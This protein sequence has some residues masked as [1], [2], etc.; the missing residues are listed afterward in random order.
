MDHL[1][2]GTL[3]DRLATQIGEAIL[4]GDYSSGERLDEQRLAEAYAVSR[5]PV[6]EALRQL[7]SSGLIEIRPHRGAIVATITP[8]RL[9]ELFVAMG[10]IEATCA[11]LAAISMSP[12]ERRQLDAL[13]AE[14]G[15]LARKG[16]RAAYSAANHALHTQIYAG[17]HNAMLEE[18][19]LGLRRR[20]EHFRR[21][22][23]RA[24]RRLVQS[25]GE[26]ADVVRAILTGDAARAHS[27]MLHHVSLVEIAFEKLARE[28]PSRLRKERVKHAS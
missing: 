25:H 4:A 15:A 2:D 5:T 14:M 17:A 6:R 3:A 20:L 28:T 1:A 26:H 27:A 11:R 21:A 13:H 22:Q 19:A 8:E 23:F 10:E 18:I 9:K 24:P 7:A 12:I 16:R